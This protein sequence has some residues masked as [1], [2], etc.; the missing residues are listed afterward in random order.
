MDPLALSAVAITIILSVMAAAAF[1]ARR[2][3]SQIQTEQLDL[4]DLIAGMPSLSEERPHARTALAEAA[5][6]EPPSGGKGCEI[7]TAAPDSEVGRSEDVATPPEAP[8]KSSAP[9]TPDP[10]SCEPE[11]PGLTHG[12]EVL[13]AAAAPKPPED[14]R[15]ILDGCADVETAKEVDA[16]NAPMEE[17]GAEPGPSEE[18]DAVLP[19]DQAET[20]PPS[21]EE[22]PQDETADRSLIGA[23]TGR[24]FATEH[25]AQPGHQ[26]AKAVYRDRRGRKRARQP[27]IKPTATHSERQA[28]AERAPAEVRL[29]LITHPIQ[30]TV[31]L[32][33]VL[34]RPEGFPGTASIN[35]N[36]PLTIEA[37]DDSRYDDVDIEW[38]PETLAGEL[39]YASRDGF[40]WVRS[41]RR[42]HLFAADPAEAGRVSVSTARAGVE[43]A[44]ICSEHD[45]AIVSA[46]AASTGSP[47]LHSHEGWLG[48]APGWRVLSGYTPSRNAQGI[49]DAAFRALDPGYDLQIRLSGGLALRAGVYAQGHPPGI[50]IDTLPQDVTVTIDGRQAAC[51][52]AGYW[53]AENWDAPG[54][55]LVDLIPGP[56]LTYEI[57]QDPADADGW[58]LWNAHEGRSAERGPWAQARICGTVISGPAGEAV[59]AHEARPTLV[60]LGKQAGATALSK[61]SDADVSVGLI[62]EPPEFLLVSWGPRRH[63]GEIVWL[64]LEGAGS[65]RRQYPKNAQAA[66]ANVI[67]AAVSRRLPLRP[68]GNTAG[69]DVWQRAVRRARS[70]KKRQS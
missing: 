51:N 2:M 11:I 27:E 29:R 50:A 55:H 4:R 58:P 37:Y 22:Q 65:R 24:L 13:V 48:I 56:S 20:A 3:L 17:T 9:D 38:L 34:S 10:R 64:G 41:G 63:Q 42:L 8:K 43:H 35:I 12:T 45:A 36:G 19:E 68:Q 33:L 39:R 15:A 59:I 40:Q 21:D 61:R 23:A 31:E 47:H 25:H 5:I 26:R 67:R 18:R 66:W 46:I 54:T 69:R 44:I 6:P 30:Q 28:A 60:A 70:L 7:H 57:T 62:A 1:A 49:T 53:E 52:G 32:S 14:G 16:E